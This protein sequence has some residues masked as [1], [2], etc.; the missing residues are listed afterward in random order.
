[1]ASFRPLGQF[2]QYFLNNG[3]V[4]NGGSITF[5]ET[6]LTTLKNTYSDPSL[7]VLNANPVLLDA[8]GRL[9]T[10]VWGSGIYGAVIKDALGTIIQTRNNIQSGAD[11]GFSI[12][13]LITGDFLTNDGSNLLWAPVRQVPDP[14]G[15]AGKVVGT[16]GTVV[17]WQAA[18]TPPAP[19]S[20][21]VTATS[22][23]AA[24]TTTTTNSSLVQGGSG[25]IPPS[26][27]H[28]ATGS[29]TFPVPFK[30]GTQPIV[31]CTAN[32]GGITPG[33]FYGVVSTSNITNTGFTFMVNVNEGAAQA[34]NNITSTVYF[35]YIAIGEVTSP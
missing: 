17:F 3:Q 32:G 8:A 18:T 34:P 6:D 2:N 27:G 24:D 29:V 26:G 22:L 33:G 9:T 30:T 13:A 23:R 4:N 19:A 28:T 35:S 16:D 12:P 21:T 31:T 20:I 25:N 1:M 14:T 15:Q 7:I 10:D 11:P 5:Y